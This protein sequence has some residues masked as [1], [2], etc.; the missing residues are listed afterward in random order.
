MRRHWF[1]GYGN[2]GATA[3]DAGLLET[4]TPARAPDVRADFVTPALQSLFSGGI[5]GLAGALIAWRLAEDVL[6]W[7]AI[8]FVGVLALAWAFSLGLV[9]DLLWTVERVGRLD[10]DGDGQEGQPE[11]HAM[12]VN[13]DAAR[14][15]AAQHERQRARVMRL[16]DLL[17]FVR[18]VAMKG[19]SERA[20][21]IRPG[22]DARTR[23]LAT[24][25]L[26]IGLGIA[27]W[28]DAGRPQAGWT[29]VL[30]ADEAV[31]LLKKH[32]MDVV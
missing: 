17:E 16:A 4:L 11:P 5:G 21:G 8:G 27:R 15:R 19:T 13:A 12:V 3:A 23:Y 18:Q 25:D 9:R 32:V 2:S 10:L 14:Q 29:L 22:T 30:T 28:K 26:L 31:P 24:R 7:A 1:R 20:L 6:L